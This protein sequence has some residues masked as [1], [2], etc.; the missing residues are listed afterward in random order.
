MLYHINLDHWSEKYK[1]IYK[2]SEM[3]MANSE[4]FIQWPIQ[5]WN[6]PIFSWETLPPRAFLGDL[7]EESYSH[8][9]YKIFTYL[10]PGTISQCFSLIPPTE[11]SNLCLLWTCFK[12]VFFFKYIIL[13]RTHNK[14]F[15]IHHRH[16]TGI[17]KFIII[18]KP[19]PIIF[20]IKLCNE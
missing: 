1:G 13:G 17:A 15:V 2:L 10:L 5:K 3:T 6:F 20:P 4:S 18:L 12:R 7:Q 19:L 14:R 9:N 8:S 11:I 16:F